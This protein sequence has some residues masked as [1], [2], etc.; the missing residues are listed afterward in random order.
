MICLT[1]SGPTIL[2]NLKALADNKDY[3]DICELRLDL[4]SPSEVAKAADFPSMVDIPVILTLRRVSDGGKCTLQ[5]KAR[6]SLLIDTMKNGGFS[7]V[8]IED[9]VKKSD[10]EEAAHSLGM[11]VIRSYHDF[12][13]V[14]ADIFSRVHSLASRGDVAKIAVT[15]HNTADV[16]TLFRINEEL[17]DVP[18]IIIGMGEWGVATR[19]LYKKMG[20]ILTFGSNGKAVAPGMISARELKLLY[21][22]DQLNDNTGIYGIVGNPVM[23]SLSPQI[24]NPGFHKIHYNAVYV[25]FLSESIRS[26]LTLAEMLRMRGFS[27]TV[28]FK[29]DVVKY[30]G[31]ITR[32]VKQIGSCNTV[33][34][35]PNMWK[36]TNTDYYGF[37]HPIEK[38]IDDGRIKSALVIGAGG[39]AKAIVW[40][41]KMRNVK[42][43]IVNRTKSKADELARLYGVGSDSLDNISQYEGKVDLVVQATN[44][45]LHPYEDVNPAEKFHFS[46]KEIAYDI[47]YKP[48]YT[49]FLI[50]AEKAGCTLKFGWDMLME[51]GKLQFESFTGYHYPK[52]VEVWT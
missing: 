13:G 16:M 41:L 14:P 7:Y 22:A 1:L 45:G 27:V 21:R 8:D 10:V 3:V 36:G 2:D 12:E 42:V 39:A 4:L 24:H 49:K 11:K 51:Q 25:P 44:M 26:F 46:G 5:E 15:P 6:R 9:D 20:S 34:R 32:E 23:H 19:I 28:P 37:I 38:E 52:D 30:L 50:A 17:K 35:V 31:N 48:K 47:V 33:V 40:A 18:K 43:M 29:V